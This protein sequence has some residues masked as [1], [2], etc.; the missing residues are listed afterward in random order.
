MKYWITQPVSQET[1]DNISAVRVINSYQI[2]ESSECGIIYYSLFENLVNNKPRREAIMEALLSPVSEGDVVIVQFP[3]LV[4][5]INFTTEFIDYIK[6]IKQAKAVG[7]IH[8][9]TLYEAEEEYDVKSNFILETFRKFDV[10]IVENDDIGLRLQKDE[11]KIPIISAETQVEQEINENFQVPFTKLKQ[12]IESAD[13]DIL[14]DESYFLTETQIE[15]CKNF[16]K[17]HIF[18]LM[19]KENSEKYDLL[20]FLDNQ[21]FDSVGLDENVTW[22][23]I[24]KKIVIFDANH[25]K[26]L[27]FKIRRDF[28]EKIEGHLYTDDKKEA[29]LVASSLKT[30]ETIKL[31]REEISEN[32]FPYTRMDSDDYQSLK[33]LALKGKT[34]D[35]QIG[36]EYFVIPKDELYF[37]GM[38]KF[39]NIFYE[40]E[41][42]RN[43]NEQLSKK[44]IVYMP[45]F[46]HPNH[47]NAKTRLQG[48]G[49]F[50][51][52]GIYAPANTYVLRLTENNLISGS[53]MMNTENDQEYEQRVQNL[54]KSVIAEYDIPEKNVVFIGNSRG[55]S[56]SL[57]HA[58]LGGYSA[59]AVDPIIKRDPWLVDGHD[60]QLQFDMIP[61]NFTERFNQL[62]SESLIPKENLKVFTNEHIDITYPYI[63]NL[64]QDKIEVRTTEIEDIET[65]P[66]K[67]WTF[68]V[69]T[70]PNQRELVYE[71][72]NSFE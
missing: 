64:N 24:D 62:L 50:E 32:L 36:S 42:P 51:T 22:E 57:L 3:L 10:L 41:T 52:I 11:V 69:N 21:K 8:H 4:S 12:W 72:L 19:S 35:G 1:V 40:V 28:S 7:L 55:G 58:L 23:I 65:S 31:G 16:L 13:E 60:E 53:Y 68:I 27:V 15:A 18:Y 17:E 49:R 25:Q 67:H 46:N 43:K 63:M 9:V 33:E 5:N 45:V 61:R 20:K 34:I 47:I 39:G 70:R 48:Q 2:N 56:A 66:N 6:N 29:M 54:V 30:I 37:Y 44:L 14:V 26:K 71:I 59:V 38:K